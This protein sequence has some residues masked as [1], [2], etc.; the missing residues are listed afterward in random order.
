MLNERPLDNQ[1]LEDVL[2]FLDQ[3]IGENLTLDYKREISPEKAK[4]NAELC[5][6]VSALANSAGGMI[7]YG[8]DEKKPE[9]TPVLPP[10]G[11]SRYVGR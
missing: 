7:L 6:D 8:V 11:I 10:Y 3:G 4:D 9:R 1:D 5:K 2:E